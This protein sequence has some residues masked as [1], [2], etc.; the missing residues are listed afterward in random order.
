MFG[1][2]KCQNVAIH[3]TLGVI[4]KGIKPQRKQKKGKYKTCVGKT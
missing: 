3:Q 1:I 2:L 4:M